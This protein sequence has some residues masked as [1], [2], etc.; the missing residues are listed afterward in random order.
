[1]YDYYQEKQ[2]LSEM[3]HL[4]PVSHGGALKP[5]TP[6]LELNNLMPLSLSQ[7]D[8]SVLQQLPEELKVDILE[9]L[10]AHRSSNNLASNDIS[11][12]FTTHDFV[13]EKPVLI[14]ELWIGCPPKWVENFR[15]SNCRVL[16]AFAVLFQTSGATSQFS[17][18]LQRIISGIHLPLDLTLNG[19]D[20]SVNCL[21]ELIEQY[22]K[23]KVETDIEEIYVCVRLLRR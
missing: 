7:V 9:S 1:M 4:V 2:H 15:L 13:S 16:N 22:V 17:S 5:D 10:P 6:L 8:C 20:D 19:M 11:S 18:I 12:E 14:N 21:S 3:T 23:F